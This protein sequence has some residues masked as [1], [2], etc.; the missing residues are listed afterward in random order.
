MTARF[1]RLGE[2]DRAPVSFHVDGEPVDALEG[3]TLMVAILTTAGSLRQSEFGDGARAGFCLM[4]ACQ[5][6]W[7]WTEDGTKLRAC[8]TLAVQGLRITT[9]EP[10]ATWLNIA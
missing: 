1:H 7:V 2:R 10:E 8:S 9:R 4:A 3:D 5:D 6:C